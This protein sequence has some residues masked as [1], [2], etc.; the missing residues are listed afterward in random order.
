MRDDLLVL[1]YHGVSES[2]PADISLT[3]ARLER[4]LT[5]VLGRGYR[6][7][8]LSDGLSG[9]GRRVVVTFDDAFLSVFELGRPLLERLGVPGTLFVP[10]GQAGTGEPMTWPGV[11]HWK[12]TQYADELIGMTWDQVRTL[13]DEGWE[14]GAHTRTH[15]RLTTL[16]DVGV[17]FELAGSKHDLEE[18]LGSPCATL[19]YPY[20][21]A[22]PRVEAAAGEAGFAIAVGLSSKLEA[23][24]RTLC[25]PR[26]GIYQADDMRRFRLKV[27]PQSRRLRS[28]STWAALARRHRSRSAEEK[29]SAV[30]PVDLKRTRTDPRVAV[31]IPCYGDGATVAETVAS[32]DEPEPVEVVIVDDGSPD[33]LTRSVLA[34]LEGDGTRVVRHDQ[35]RGLPSARNTGLEATSAPFVFPLDSDDLAVPGALTIMADRLERSAGAAACYGDWLEFGPHEKVRAVPRKFDPYVLAFKNRYPVES[36]FRRTALDQAG[37]WQS[38][39]GMVGYEDWNLWM[40]LAESGAEIVFAGEGVL[41]VRY[42]VH[43]S[44]MF[45]EAAKNHGTLYAK[46][47]ELHPRLYSELP[48]YRRD[49]SLNLVMRRVYPYLFGSRA[50]RG[51]WAR[52]ERVLDRV[53][54]R[55][56]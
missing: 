14:I 13:R 41:T 24:P 44:R 5:H 48:D 19:A 50:P 54:R 32:I 8:K 37:G 22:D 36:M 43:G 3:P 42:R 39:G 18:A 28:T 16:D 56:D 35:N 53:R 4:Q 15:P 27:S 47:R 46:L 49:S 30:P 45:R 31:I 52:T 40:T 25:W 51:W 9:S 10:T 34:Q 11:D 26:V 21:D 2:W 38:V 6:P 23:R 12:G 33:E 55:G 7:C 20:G 29:V 1:C 17:E